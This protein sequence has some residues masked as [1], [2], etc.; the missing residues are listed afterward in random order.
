MLRKIDQE[1]YI[2]LC[3]MAACVTELLKKDPMTNPDDI[4]VM[5]ES[6]ESTGAVRLFRRIPRP[7]FPA[8]QHTLCTVLHE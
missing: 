2:I 8:I 5:F 7:L 6:P 1:S 3:Q 4:K